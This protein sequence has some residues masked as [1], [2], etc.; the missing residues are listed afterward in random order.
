MSPLKDIDQQRTFGRRA[1]IL[2]GGQVLLGG[3]LLW[4]MFD[5]QVRNSE[6]YAVLSEENRINTHILIPPRGR[7]LDR[8]GVPIAINQEDYRVLIVPEQV[9]NLG[10]ILSRVAAVV[11]ITDDDRARISRNRRRRRRFQPLVLK[12]GLTWEQVAK[13]E[14][15]APD[16][17]GLRIERGLS[18]NYPYDAVAHVLGYVGPV[19]DRDK[20][21]GRDPMFDLPEFRIGKAG[22]ER[23]Y[24]QLL[25]GRSGTKVVEI[26]A[27][28]RVQ[29]ELRRKPGTAGADVT[30]TLDI[31]LQA[32]V[33]GRIAK[34]KAAA[35]VVV[36]ILTGDVLAMASTPGY[37]PNAFVQGISPKTWRS[38]RTNPL[39]PLTN[40]AISGT[41]APGST[42]KMLV[43][44]AG[45]DSGLIQPH[46]GFVCPGHF[47]LGSARFHCWR[48]GGHG[49][50]SLHNGIKQSCDVYFY[51]VAHRIGIQRIHDMAVRL[52]LGAQ[53]GIDL[54]R[55]NPGLIP[56]AAWK[57]KYVRDRWYPGETVV[58]GIG[59]GYVL[60]TPLQLAVMT[61][62]LATGNAVTP[63]MVRKED[64][65][66]PKFS[67]MGINPRHL[68]A[69]QKA[70]SGVTNEPG[71]TAFWTRIVEKQFAMAGK[72]GT[73]QVR[74]I[75]RAERARGVI[76]NKDLPWE[77]RDHALFVAF[78]PVDNP[79]Y[80]VA[81]IVEH[82]GSG[83]RAAAPV[84][85]DILL[86]AQKRRSAT[87]GPTGPAG[88][89][90]TKSGSK[91]E[92]RG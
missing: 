28:G 92:R 14:I 52:G 91:G 4:R 51:N 55:E 73:S 24:D 11:E 42:F 85:K 25:R 90:G 60:T 34:E 82:G 66:L 80:A 50:V 21:P 23:T 47:S 77:R 64:A 31:G 8:F 27:S 33:A 78:A 79:R 46:T 39:G 30:S 71:G 20:R 61:A 81:V 36:D 35:A 49:V 84:A 88:G 67:S 44:L 69:V 57:K 10:Q 16:L 5:L 1:A 7:I 56:T 15:N 13:L 29:R 3:A 86:T 19:T 22:L 40:K 72:T 74:R 68:A 76:R 6:K 87:V 83:S 70:M 32:Y 17:A 18:R 2:V 63:R 75:T 53:T 45:L 89:S 12:T 26:N 9:K 48:R 62:R 38:L 43:A 59:Q 65:G 41:Y 37:E 54:P 58:A